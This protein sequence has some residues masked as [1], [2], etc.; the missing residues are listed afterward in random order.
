MLIIE[1]EV[2]ISELDEALSFIWAELKTD[3]YGKRMDWRKKE[4]LLSSVDDLLDARI[5]L[6][7]R[8]QPSSPDSL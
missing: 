7:N 8:S 6:I 5:D 4:L 2:T 1:E 3:E